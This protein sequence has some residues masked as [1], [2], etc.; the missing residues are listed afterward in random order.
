MQAE[1]FLPK[2][3]KP[4]ALFVGDAGYGQ[5]MKTAGAAWRDLPAAEKEEYRLKSKKEFED[6][7][8]AQTD[9]ENKLARAVAL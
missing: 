1:G 9:L 8:K 5:D 2:A 6:L 7:K 4:F 3:R